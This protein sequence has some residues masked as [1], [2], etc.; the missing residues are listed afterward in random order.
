MIK[1]I[2]TKSRWRGFFL[3]LAVV[4]P[5]IITS[6]VDNDAGGIATYSI[7]GA[8][9]GYSLIWSLIPIT[10]ALIVIQEMSARM[11]VVTGKGLSDLI[12]E[13]FGVKITFYL[14][15]ALIFTNFGN[16]IA[17]FAGIAASL[18]IFH[19]SKYVSVPLGALF[20][21][22][23]VVKGTYK[24]VEKVFLAACLIYV[25]YIISG[26]LADPDWGAVKE[27]VVSPQLDLSPGSLAMLVGLIGTTIAPWM[28]FYLQSAVVEKNVRLRN[29]KYSRADVISGSFMVNLVAFFIIVACAA[30]ISKAGIRI[31]TAKDAALALTPLAGKYASFLFAIGLLNASLFAASILPLSTAYVVCEGM[32]WEQGVDKKFSQAPQFYGLYSLL[33]FL[34]AGV[35]LWPN[36]PLIPIMFIS[37][38]INGVVL[39]VILVFILIL[40]NNKKIMGSYTNGRGFN[41]LAWLT[42]A[43]LVALSVTLLALMLGV[44]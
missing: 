8:H 16:T 35:V 41:I 13:N 1:R 30:T 36:L 22:M 5:G 23:L 6:N 3:L 15:M 27:S 28:Q 29:Y 34:G 42:V 12:R 31:E 26:F 11:G 4:G 37:Q 17:E 25:G 19:V 2:L 7:A 18:E 21:W 38:V 33:I 44:V 14:L 10:L 43:V 20:V 32:G 40:I 9:F 39:P 24:S